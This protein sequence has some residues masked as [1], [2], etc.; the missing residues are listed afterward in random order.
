MHEVMLTPSNPD[1]YRSII[2]YLTEGKYA[3]H[4]YQ[5]KS[6]RAY[7]VV[8]RGLHRHIPLHE[9]TR[10]IEEQGHNVRGVTN[11]LHP[12]SKMPMPLFFVDLEPAPNNSDIFNISRIFYSEVRVEEPHKRS[13]VV[14]CTRCQQFRH[15]K[16]YCNRPPRC[17]R[18]AGEH[19]STT[20]LKSRDTPATC[21]LCSRDH[22]ANYRECQVYKDL[23]NAARK[24]TY[25]Q[26]KRSVDPPPMRASAAVACSSCPA[27]AP[28][29]A[30]TPSRPHQL[31]R[32]TTS[33]G[34]QGPRPKSQQIS[35]PS[36]S[37]VA[38][39]NARV[40]IKPSGVPQTTTP[41]PVPQIPTVPIPFAEVLA[42]FFN[43]FRSLAEGLVTAIQSMSSLIASLTQHPA[44]TYQYRD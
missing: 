15:T 34:V 14:Q 23:Q 7:R 13:D 31:P 27:T 42:S 16:S 32:S 28:G 21:A 10:D 4:T 38:S 12:K 9:I 20:C 18:C 2:R 41:H 1:A 3:F 39:R 33:T 8:L 30:A 24:K 43:E 17:V 36:Y 6:E 11:A 40:S 19:D 26:E 29:V 37:Q 25:P 22:P 44:I 35:H 5:I